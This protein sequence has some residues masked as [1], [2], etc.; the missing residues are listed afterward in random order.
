MANG[1]STQPVTGRHDRKQVNTASE[2]LVAPVVQHVGLASKAHVINQDTKSG[3]QEGA[4][5]VHK[6]AAGDL[7]FAFATG[8]RD[9]SA[10]A[11][12]T[13]TK[14]TPA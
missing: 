1:Y 3:K 6:A 13:A 10:W 7:G 12:H 11:V 5:V 4:V 14:V 9:T 8:A 2:H